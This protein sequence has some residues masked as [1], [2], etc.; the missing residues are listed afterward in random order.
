MFYNIKILAILQ[1]KK[2]EGRCIIFPLFT[3]IVL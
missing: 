2:R 3:I 1:N